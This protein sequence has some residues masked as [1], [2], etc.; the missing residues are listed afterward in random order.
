MPIILVFSLNISL[1]IK[2]KLIIP[3]DKSHHKY[4][5]KL[6]AV[7]ISVSGDADKLQLKGQKSRLCNKKAFVKYVF[8]K[9]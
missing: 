7:C 1:Y 5:N 6:Y 2:K 4:I 3:E 8:R 9:M